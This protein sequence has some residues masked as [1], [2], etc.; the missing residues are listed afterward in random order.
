MAEIKTRSL[1]FVLSTIIFILII[2]LSAVLIFISYNIA[3]R[4]I[5]N[6][7]INQI[8]NFSS[9][10]E[11][12]INHFYKNYLNLAESLGRSN[13]MINA[14]KNGDFTQAIE[15]MTKYIET[16]GTLENFFLGSLNDPWPII[17]DGVGGNSVGFPLVSTGNVECLTKSMEG[18]ANVGSVEASPI[19]GR[20][21]A[22]LS[23]P[24]TDGKEIY[25]Y[26]N[27]APELNV[28]SEQIL[29]NITIAENG[30]PYI[31]TLEGLIW[32]HPDEEKI[33]QINLAEFDWGKKILAAK[34]GELVEYV[35]DG[36]NMLAVVT[37]NEENGFLSI[38]TIELK[39]IINAA[40]SMIVMMI[41]IGISGT[42]L[43][44]LIIYLLLHSRF[45]PIERFVPI[46]KGL[47]EGDLTRN[48]DGKIYKD[49]IGTIIN[50]VMLTIDKLSSI[51]TEIYQ[52]ALLL[53]D[54]S[55][56]IAGTSQSL[57]T[58]SSQLAANVEEISSSIEQMSANTSAN[59][60][61][62]AQTEKISKTTSLKAGEGGTA[63][64]ETVEAMKKISD[65]IGLIDEIASKTNMLALN[66]AIEAARA[67]ELGR[68]FAVV[69]GEVKKLAERSQSA[70][71]DIVNLT[72]SSVE[73]AAHAGKLFE[74]ILPD[75]QSTSG[76][77]QEISIASQEQNS[78]II[79][80]N[81]GMNQL[82]D[83]TQQTASSA[84]E[85]AA[86]SETLEE[87]AVHLK[88]LIEFF[89]IK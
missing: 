70:A 69:A 12:Q 9:D 5:R 81:D 19:T 63:V 54:A 6:S 53:S 46:I 85:L 10:I 72:E 2:L 44:I 64:K 88:E 67:G 22:F 59:T 33:L 77:I 39:D 7:Y 8:K 82:N 58:G 17:A 71:Q 48:Y 89:K 65:R 60:Q 57:S 20:P 4:E 27:I 62:A 45:K 43:T 83:I 73:I 3:F 56:E 40:N 78:G 38:A 50:A 49:E 31:A 80:I 21:V 11:L 84:E 66:A 87:H 23:A 47:S 37:R 13:I 52:G 15:V 16:S 51:V 1:K 30:Y 26:I 35:S 61:N 55:T 79:Q 68:G 34:S 76:L 24:V 75:I 18:T 25:G 29:K 28:F 86:T 32:A 42:M 36:N 74:E 41:I 14:Y